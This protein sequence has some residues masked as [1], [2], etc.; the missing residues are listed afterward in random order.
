MQS[1]AK[2]FFAFLICLLQFCFLVNDLVKPVFGQ[3]NSQ[4]SSVL[5]LRSFTP[6]HL[7][8]NLSLE[9]GSISLPQTQVL[10]GSIVVTSGWLVIASSS[11]QTNVGLSLILHFW[12]MFYY[13][14]TILKPSSQS[15]SIFKRPWIIDEN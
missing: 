7:I 13:F 9:I 10:A 1:F 2:N 12:N 3:V 6:K 5:C 11:L 8:L 14:R 15:C 4:V